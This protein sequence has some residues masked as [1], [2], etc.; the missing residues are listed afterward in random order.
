MQDL[1]FLTE[2]DRVDLV[3]E[4]SRAPGET[5]L[6]E[7][8]SGFDDLDAGLALDQ[9]SDD[10]DTVEWA[11]PT[12]SE[13]YTAMTKGLTWRQLAQATGGV[14]LLVSLGAATA[15]LVFHNRVAQLLR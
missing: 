9:Q 11:R 7:F 1:D 3:D 14:L 4:P 13:M 5:K 6:S 10:V 15:A 12:E 8:H 2:L